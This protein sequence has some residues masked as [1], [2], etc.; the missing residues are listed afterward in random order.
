MAGWA[1]AGCCLLWPGKAELGGRENLGF[2]CVPGQAGMWMAVPSRSI[3]RRSKAGGGEVVGLGVE[4][5]PGMRHL[6]GF[7]MEFFWI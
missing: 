1:A 6:Y 3:S 4:I 7:Y 2:W 5:P